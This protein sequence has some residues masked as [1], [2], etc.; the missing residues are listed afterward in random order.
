MAN[1]IVYDKVSWHYPEG[2]NCP[3]L[4]AA[5]IHFETVMEWLK[6]NSLLSGEGEEIFEIG[7]DADF[8]ITSPMLNKKGNEIFKKYYSTWIKSIDYSNKIDFNI[9]DGG[10][11]EYKGI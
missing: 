1:I 8:S 9:L 10:F 4:E 5:K 3:N 6:R 7:I 2:Q 11:R